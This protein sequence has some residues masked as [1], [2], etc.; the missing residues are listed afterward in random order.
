M[1]GSAGFAI[2]ITPWRFFVSQR[3][4][5]YAPMEKEY[6]LLEALEL[7]QSAL[8]TAPRF[9]VHSRDMDSYDIASICGKVIKKEKE[10]NNQPNHNNG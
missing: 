2:Y 1:E 9:K 6:T 5:Q 4:N 8:N 10:R 7:A 3:N